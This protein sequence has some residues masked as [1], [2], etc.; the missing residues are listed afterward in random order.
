MAWTIGQN[1]TPV[2]DY[3]ADSVEMTFHFL[4]PDQPAM[5]DIEIG[6]A[7]F[8]E[9]YREHLRKRRDTF[10]PVWDLRDGAEEELT[11]EEAV[12]LLPEGEAETLKEKIKNHRVE[13]PGDQTIPII[14]FVNQHI[15]RVEGVEDGEG[16]PVEKWDDVGHA[17]RTAILRHMS[18]WDLA[19]LHYELKAAAALKPSVKND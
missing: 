9:S 5:L 1:R 12:D 17:D 2:G 15:A 3:F 10:G 4:R 16:N 18:I 19:N 7:D 11:F 14:D 6:G 13:I 8:E